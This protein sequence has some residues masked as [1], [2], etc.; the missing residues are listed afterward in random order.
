MNDNLNIPSKPKR[1]SENLKN[2]NKRMNE[3]I[4]Y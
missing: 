2:L 4:K 1:M 3:T